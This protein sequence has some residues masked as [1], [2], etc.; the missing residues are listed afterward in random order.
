MYGYMQL[1]LVG[2]QRAEMEGRLE[3]LAASNGGTV[4][5]RVFCEEGPPIA[6]LWSMLLAL[7]ERSGGRAAEQ[8]RQL[9]WREGFDLK[10][11]LGA[12]PPTSALWALLDALSRWRGS[13]VI[14]PSPDHFDGLGVTS[15]NIKL[16][17]AEIAAFNEAARSGSIRFEEHTVREAVQLYDQMID[18][19]TKVRTK[20]T[21]AQDATGFG[22][23]A[24][25]QDLQRGFS[26]KAA[27]GIGVINQLI[28]GAMRLQEAFLRAGQLI[29]EADQLNAG[30]IKLLE[31]TP[32][33]GS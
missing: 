13:C 29:S 23:F 30:R 33:T 8:L 32:G 12:A 17:Q 21:R 5:G 10:R 31:N 7:D 11:L 18:G 27:E 14:V 22:G 16:G 4:Q 20:L 3:E 19:L 6:T 9:A 26:N 24:S 28:D 15:A 25:G 1:R 2:S